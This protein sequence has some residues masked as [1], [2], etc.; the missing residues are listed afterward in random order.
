MTETTNTAVRIRWLQT[1]LAKPA[2][3]SAD[4]SASMPPIM[5]LCI[6]SSVARLSSELQASL[7]FSNSFVA[8]I[9]LLYI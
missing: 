3:L 2:S 9:C 8:V 1:F 4:S 6:L 7:S 5:K